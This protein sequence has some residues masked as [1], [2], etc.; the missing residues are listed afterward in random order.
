M[1]KVALKKR[2][3]YYAL[4]YCYEVTMKSITFMI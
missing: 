2:M 4:I 1:G 3:L